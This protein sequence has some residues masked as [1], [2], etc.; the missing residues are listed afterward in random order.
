M[1][2]HHQIKAAADELVIFGLK[3]EEA[4][5]S[6]CVPRVQDTVGKIKR[7]PPRAPETVSKLLGRDL[8]VQTYS[9]VYM[10]NNRPPIPLFP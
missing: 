10:L 1:Q 5:V 6:E 2:Q 8:C 3:Q 7:R 4:A 9:D